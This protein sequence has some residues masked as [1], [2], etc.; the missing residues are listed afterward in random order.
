MNNDRRERLLDAVQSLDD[1]YDIIDE[2][3]AEEQEAFDNLTEGLQYSATGDS[4]QNAISGMESL[5]TEI[6]NIKGKV[7]VMAV[8]P[9]RK[10]K[11]S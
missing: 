3:C 10:K 7:H 4:M 8:P 11:K 1:A 9:K 5:M 6:E 2:V